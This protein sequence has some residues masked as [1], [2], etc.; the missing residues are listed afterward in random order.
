MERGKSSKAP[1]AG[2]LLRRLAGRPGMEEAATRNAGL[3]KLGEDGCA[4]LLAAR[5]A[6]TPNEPRMG[7]RGP[8][9]GFAVLVAEKDLVRVCWDQR[10]KRLVGAH[11]K[12]GGGG[13]WGARRG[14]LSPFR[15]GVALIG[16]MDLPYIG[17]GLGGD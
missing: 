12:R 9:P 13:G 7:P 4:H 1:A 17:R 3:G 6:V 15:L 8:E 5:A 16:R 14:G 11:E 2:L 10:W